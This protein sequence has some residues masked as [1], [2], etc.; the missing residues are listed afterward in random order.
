MSQALDTSPP[1]P[2]GIWTREARAMLRLAGPL[3]LVQVAQIAVQTVDTIMIGRLGDRELAAASLG[4]NLFSIGFF[5]CLGIVIATSP[6]AA[7]AYGARDMRGFRRVVRQGLWVASAVAV[8][9]VV[10]QVFTEPLLLLAGQEAELAA[11]AEGYLHAFMWGTFPALWLFAFRAFVTALDRTAPVVWAGVLGLALNAFLNWLLIYGNWGFPRLELVGAGIA[12]SISNFCMAGGLGL[13]LMLARP[14]RKF[15]ILGRFWKPDWETFLAILTLGLPVGVTILMEAG[16]FAV[17]AFIMGW[18][19]AEAVA[20]HHIAL[21]W[22][23]ITFMVPLGLGQAATVRV[24]HAVCRRDMP[25]ARRAG[26]AAIVMAAGFMCL[27]AIAFWTLPGPLSAAFLDPGNPGNAEALALA[28]S[29][30]AV[31]AF[32]QIFDGLQVTGAAALRGLSDTKVPMWYAVIGY[33]ALGL[34]AMLLLAFPGGLDGVGIWAGLAIGL[35]VAAVLMVRRFDRLTAGP[36]RR[37]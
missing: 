23:A 19:S 15:A 37:P 28:A 10:L 9:A 4:F 26:L 25:A 3:I 24:G 12:S 35:G 31:A 5:L 27:T 11:L 17:S 33:W 22:A 1:D 14:Y 34:S 13:Y 36:G 8:P 6:L 20:G 32:F 2:A 16:M 21:Q 7:Q 18:I 29:F 30:L